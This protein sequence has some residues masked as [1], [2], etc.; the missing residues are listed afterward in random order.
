[1]DIVILC[2]KIAVGGAERQVI[3]EAKG[4]YE[5]GYDVTIALESFDPE[6]ADQIGLPTGVKVVSFDHSMSALWGGSFLSRIRSVRSVLQSINPDFI[7]SHYQDKETYLAIKSMARDIPFTCQV[8][9][10]PLWFENNPQLAPHQRKAVYDDLI[11][12]VPGHS[13]FQS[14]SKLSV[15]ERLNAEIREF[16]RTKALRDSA[17][18]FVLTNRVATEVEALY[19][20][21]PHIVRPGV[22]ADWIA[23]ADDVPTTQLMDRE[24][25]ILSVSRLDPRKRLSTLLRALARIDTERSDVGL[26]IGGEGPQETELRQLADDLGVSEAV[27]FAGRIPDADLPTYY[28]SADVFACPAWMSYGLVPLEAYAM[29]TKVALSTDTGVREI[30]EGEPGI[31]V[32]DPDVDAWST[33]LVG[34]LESDVDTWNRDVIPTWGEFCAEKRRILAENGY[35]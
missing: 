21:T 28:K 33:A 1:M 3:E 26:V 24:H 16:F 14:H 2:N 30:L 18:T 29:R 32:V 31:S 10:S 13:Q 9:G 17:A 7:F 19:G 15:E 25:V 34:L 35:L 8:N 20:V 23:R 11:D 27:E 4:F 6:F 12:A 22:S 5:M